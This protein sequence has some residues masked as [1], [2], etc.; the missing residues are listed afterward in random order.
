MTKEA[1]D[2]RTAFRLHGGTIRKK[3]SIDLSRRFGGSAEP[4]GRGEWLWRGKR[5]GFPAEESSM[6]DGKLSMKNLEK[7]RRKLVTGGNGR[8]LV[9][10]K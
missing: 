10:K 9:K 4:F 8:I 2:S 1:M 6:G 7:K 3:L 5:E